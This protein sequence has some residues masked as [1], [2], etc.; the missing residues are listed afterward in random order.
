M[1]TLLRVA[2]LNEQG[3]PV[4]EMD[5]KEEIFAVAG[6]EATVHQAVVRVLAGRRRG[7]AATRNRAAV[8]GGGRKPWRQKG[9]GRARAGS[10]RSPLWRGGGVVFGPRPRDYAFPL[11]KK[12][13]RLALRAALSA[14]LAAGKLIVV[15]ALRIPKP[16]TKEVLDIL[17]ALD[18][19]GRVLIVTAAPEG[20][21]T[22]AV[23][24]LPGAK[25]AAAA[26]LNAYEVLAHEKIVL[27]REAVAK[28]EEV[29]G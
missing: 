11:P 3:R 13:R 1:E 12:M 22:R 17:R 16:K 14:K 23:R 6:K 26:G 15:D 20:D 18:A 2:V 28:L 9:T 21:L 27:T 19:G 24:N 5:L 8:A 7:T 29:L 25:V 10:I 4:G